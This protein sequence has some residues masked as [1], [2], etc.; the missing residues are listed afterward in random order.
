[1]AAAALS[2]TAR[3]APLDEAS[4]DQ[5]KHEEA[6]LDRAGI[7]AAWSKGPEWARTAL[8]KDKLEQVRRLIEVDEQ[9]AFRCVIRQRLPAQAAA[10][11]DGKPAVEP[12]AKAVPKSKP[13]AKAA[14]AVDTPAGEQA[15]APP[16]Q[17]KPP[18]RPKAAQAPE[19]VVAPATTASTV[20]APASA[21]PL[22]SVT[23]PAR[24]RASDAFVPADRGPI[25]N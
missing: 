4:C 15:A 6:A 21:A 2:L 12:K 5:L 22:P 16:V 23:R 18:A 19:R 9:L 24:P 3:A 1:M 13:N 20:T 7:R 14:A 25:D 10:A 17:A 8:G 11:P